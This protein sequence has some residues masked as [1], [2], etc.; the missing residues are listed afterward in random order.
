MEKSRAEKETDAPKEVKVY[1]SYADEFVE[2]GDQ[3][4]HLPEDYVWIHQNPLYRFAS[5]LT[6]GA[7]MIFGAFYTGCVL[8]VSFKNREVLRECEKGGYFLFGNHTQPVGDAF[9]P[10]WGI[11]PKRLRTV[12]GPAN[13]GIPLLGKLL[14]MMGALPIP[15]DLSGMKE[16]MKA[17]ESRVTE[18]NVIVI[19]PEAHVWP[20]C[21][22]VRP[23]KET[24]FQFPVL[25]KKPSY[26]MTTTY[27][28]RKHGEKP[29]ITVYFDGP[30][31]PDPSLKRKEAQKKLH[32]EIYACMKKRSENSTYEYVSY[33]KE[34]EL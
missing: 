23:Y 27:Q 22:F 10:G 34:N 1:K 33:V 28:K 31:Y 24:A 16:F 15:E 21:T 2:S 5:C 20:Y 18:G 32:D 12:C 17:V 26:C 4:L 7:G 19:Y 6:Y 29:R 9:T 30:F 14:P 3:D 25:F 11:F 13:L 8:H